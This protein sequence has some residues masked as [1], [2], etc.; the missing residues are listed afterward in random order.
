M[1]LLDFAN[2]IP[3]FR[4]ELKIQHQASDI[5]FITVAAVI[6]GVQDWEDIEYFGHCKD[7]ALRNQNNRRATAL[8]P[9][10]KKEGK[11]YTLIA[12]SLNRQGF[13]TS[14]GCRF[15]AVQVWRLYSKLLK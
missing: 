15:Y 5:V 4:Q 14:K 9:M 6:C 8:I 2:S 7:N 13:K 3:D 10:M 1:N 12:E 11:T